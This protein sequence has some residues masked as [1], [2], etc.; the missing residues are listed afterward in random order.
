[1]STKIRIALT[2]VAVA[3]VAALWFGNTESLDFPFDVITQD[4]QPGDTVEIT[5]GQ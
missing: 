4:V 5:I 2:M 1:M 3:A